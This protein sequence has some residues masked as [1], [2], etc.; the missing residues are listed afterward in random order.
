MEGAV[1]NAAPILF[2]RNFIGIL[3]FIFN[4][5]SCYAKI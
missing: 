1:M 4:F 5:L 2:G 3:Q